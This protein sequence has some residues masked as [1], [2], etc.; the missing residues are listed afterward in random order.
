[1]PLHSKRLRTRGYNQALEIARPI[2]RRLQ[3]SLKPSLLQRV[4]NTPQQQG[5][6][7]SERRRNLRNAFSTDSHIKADKVLLVDDVMTTG[8]TVR[9]CSRVL[10]ASGIKE[11]RVAV[12]GRA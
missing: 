8:E 6:S 9:E 2:A 1:V 12:A 11:V 3:V 5:L 10:I 7:A 4:R